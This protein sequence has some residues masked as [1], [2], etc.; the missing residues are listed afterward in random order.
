MIIINKPENFNGS[1]FALEIGIEDNFIAVRQNE[2]IIEGDLDQTY[3]MEKLK[4]HKPKPFINHRAA[5]L[6]KLIDL[7]LTEEEI[8]AL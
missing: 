5:A 8:A 7:G 2:I 6:S 3:I 4:T 1:Q